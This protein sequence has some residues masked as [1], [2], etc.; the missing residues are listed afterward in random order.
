MSRNFLVWSYLSS[1]LWKKDA[2]SYKYFMT[3]KWLL[4]GST[5]KLYVTCT[6]SKIYWS[7]FFMLKSHFDTISCQNIY[8]ER[9][10]LSDQLFKEGAQ[11]DHDTWLI[12]K[13]NGAE[14]YQY[15]PRPFIVIHCRKHSHG[16]IFCFSSYITTDDFC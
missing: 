16:I 10:T 11:Q 8:R 3:P 1:L 4:I 7:I 5:K 12:S 9:N 6:H 2:D 14:F 15:Y 13:E